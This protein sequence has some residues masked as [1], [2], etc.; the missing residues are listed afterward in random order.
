[1]ILK[2]NTK[3]NLGLRIL[4]RR[5]DNLHNIATLYTEIDF[6]D[7][8]QINK[9]EKGCSIKSNVDWIPLDESNLCFKAYDLLSKQAQK[10]L[11][12]SIYINKSGPGTHF[13]MCSRS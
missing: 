3:L 6:G 4:N 2:S 9:Q 13:K 1:M 7:E 11:G 5:K 12:I 10:D 8:I